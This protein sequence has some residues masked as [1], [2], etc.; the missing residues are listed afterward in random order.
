MNK[1][2]Q[3]KKPLKS[4]KIQNKFSKQVFLDNKDGGKILERQT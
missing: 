4:I 3:G 2:V 1:S